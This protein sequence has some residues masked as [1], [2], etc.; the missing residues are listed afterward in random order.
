[1]LKLTIRNQMLVGG[2]LVML[3]VVT[4]G[5]YTAPLFH[6]QDAT[7]AVFFLAGVYLTPRWVFLPLC[8]VAAL[9]DWIAIS[10]G[11]VSGF[12]VT[13]AYAMLLPAFASLWL[14]GRWFAR[15]YSEAPKALL[16][17]VSLVLICAFMAELL[18]S[19]GFYFFG[20]RFAEPSLAVFFQ[21]ILAYF[22]NSLGAMAIYLGIA[23][24]FHVFIVRRHR[25]TTVSHKN[26]RNQ[27]K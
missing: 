19:G 9:V 12:C 23:I 2:G 21:R 4:R 1:M 15:H 17:L 5:H 6:L 14:G 8:A 25:Y 10:W 26:F 7:W 27:A 20:G 3:M 18:S 13:P 22:P 24:F 16:S 11:G